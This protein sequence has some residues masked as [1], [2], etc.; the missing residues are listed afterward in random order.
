MTGKKVLQKRLA[1]KKTAPLK[2]IPVVTLQ[3]LPPLHSFGKKDNLVP[4]A[5]KGQ[6]SEILV[7]V[8]NKSV[9]M[10]K[11][12]KFISGLHPN[13]CEFVFNAVIGGT[14]SA[15][16]ARQ[17]GFASWVSNLASR[18]KELGFVK[19]VSEYEII[20]NY[21]NRGG[22]MI[23]ALADLIQMCALKT[24]A[25]IQSFKEFPR[26]DVEESTNERTPKEIEVSVSI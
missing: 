17:L 10:F 2:N 16:G 15:R 14:G 20:V 23:F 22:K 6:I 12:A 25:A 4:S 9:S 8:G 24:K 1:A 13:V 11:D 26:D 18:F 3:N 7:R 5:E 21:A 19:D